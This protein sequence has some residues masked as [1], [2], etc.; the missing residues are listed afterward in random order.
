MNYPINYPFSNVFSRLGF[1]LV[2]RIDVLFDEEANV[3]IATSTD[4]KGLVLEAETF[5]D[6]TC[7]VQEAIVNL[8][9]LNQQKTVQTSADVIYKNHIAIA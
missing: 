6:L 8:R 9:Q 5:H 7:E 1:T 3:Y 2:V 4:M